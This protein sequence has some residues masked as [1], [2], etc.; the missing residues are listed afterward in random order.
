LVNDRRA[1]SRK[2]LSSYYMVSG[3]WVYSRYVALYIHTGYIDM[4]NI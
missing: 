3:R 1:N 4:I 2:A